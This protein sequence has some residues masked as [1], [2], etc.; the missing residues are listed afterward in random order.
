MEATPKFAYDAL[1]VAIATETLILDKKDNLKMPL[2]ILAVKAEEE[3]EEEVLEQDEID[4]EEAALNSLHSIRIQRGKM[5]FM[6]F[7]KSNGNGGDRPKTT[8]G[9]PMKCRYCKKLGHMQ[10]ECYKWIKENGVMITR[11]GKQYR[12]N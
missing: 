12:A 5:P 6:K 2:K 7:P 9:E 4:L 3:C 1:K 10:R 8:N 11:Q